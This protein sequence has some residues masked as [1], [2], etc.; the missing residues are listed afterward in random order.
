MSINSDL[1]RSLIPRPFIKFLLKFPPLGDLQLHKNPRSEKINKVG[2][3][4]S[5]RYLRRGFI[6]TTIFRR[7]ISFAV[8]INFILSIIFCFKM[9]C[10]FYIFETSLEMRVFVNKTREHAATYMNRVP[11]YYATPGL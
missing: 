6:Y 8:S 4:F 11:L 2:S 5:E 1:C 10:A 9:L 7:M 3:F